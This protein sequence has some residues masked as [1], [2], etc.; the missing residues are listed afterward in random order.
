MIKVYNTLTKTK[1]EFV[2]VTP[3]KVG[4]YLCGP[5]VYK[6]SHIGHMVGPVIFDTIKRYLV[7]SGYEVTLVINITDVDDKLIAEA[8]ERK[9][10]MA[11]VAEEMTADY[12]ANLNAMGVLENVDYFPKATEH[13][14]NIVKFVEGLVAKG[15]AYESAGDVYF[16]VGKFAEYGKLSHRSLDQML[17]E[18]GGTA[19]RK[20][21]PFDFALWKSAKPGEPSW[22]SPW[23]KGRPG[24]HIECSVMSKE[25]LGKTFDI[26]GGGLDLVFPHHE[27]EVAQSE[28]LHGCVMARYWLHNGL[29]QASSEIGKV[30]GRK[31]RTAEEGDLASQE[32]GK[33]SKSKGSSAFR[34][35]L[36][37]VPA[38]TIR[39]FLLSSHYRRPIDYGM[40]RLEET[41]KAMETFYRFFKRFKEVSGKSFYDLDCPK[42]RKDGDVK[43][44]KTDLHAMPQGK[45]NEIRS[46]FLAAMDDDFNTGSAISFLFDAMR[47]LNNYIDG[48]EK[49][50]HARFPEDRLPTLI[51]GVVTFK[52]LCTTLGLFL[53][54]P[55]EKSGADDALVGK[56]VGLLIDMRAEA[57]KAKDFQ[58]ADGIRNRLKEIG[59]MLEDRP[60]GKTDWSLG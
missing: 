11:A 22:E 23:G 48:Q 50:N 32:V 39:F 53:R 58:A 29:M 25:L 18:G 10:P 37:Q 44:E 52:E 56:L 36:K 43:V 20:R 5:T 57:K 41:G 34:D 12:R 45:L 42:T 49:I 13:L 4:I 21:T 60:G 27:N 9:M 26:H 46:D 15:I 28:A 17:G 14:E 33:I 55:E 1:E 6:P 40:E 16:D 47:V 30:G 19:D 3:G 51:D 35:L 54:E 38:E 8:N 7:Y 2:P 24:W 31:T 59:I